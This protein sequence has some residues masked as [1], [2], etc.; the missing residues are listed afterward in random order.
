MPVFSAEG[1]AHAPVFVLQGKEARYRDFQLSDG[2]VQRQTPADFLPPGSLVF[3][4]DPPGVDAE[5]FYS[6]AIHFVEETA[7]K[8]NRGINQPKFVVLVL[9]GYSGHIQYKILRY[10][11][12]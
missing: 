4:R 6:W 9:D 10:S 12:S 1:V 5:I 11:P 3:Y 8:R 2:T 7:F